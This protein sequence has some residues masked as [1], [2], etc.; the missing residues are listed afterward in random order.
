MAH[1]RVFSFLILVGLGMALTGSSGMSALAA[2]ATAER[3]VAVS[4]GSARGTLIEGRCPTFSWGEVE[5]A[6]AYELVVVRVS[7]DGEESQAV[8]RER[9]PGTVESWTPSLDRCLD[10]G[11]RYAW[12]VRAAGGK[13]A[14]E[15]S[16]P[17]LF[18]VAAG[19]SEAEFEAALATV[20]RYLA[21]RESATL[22]ATKS[23]ARAGDVG[24][25]EVLGPAAAGSPPAPQ[26]LAPAVVSLVTEGAIGVGTSA[27]Q[28]DLHVLGSPT[29]GSI[30]VTP[31]EPDGQEVSE[32]FL[33]E[34]HDGSWGMK[35]QYDGPTNN[36]RILGENGGVFGP[37]LTIN[38]D[39][40]A[41]IFG[42]TITGDGSGLTSLNPSNLSGPVPVAQGGT[43]AT[44]AAGALANL[45]AA[46]A[47]DLH[48]RYT[49]S[50]AVA[51]MGTWDDANPLHHAKYTDSEALA[52]IQATGFQGMWIG[53]C[54]NRLVSQPSGSSRSCD[55]RS[56]LTCTGGGNFCVVY[57]PDTT[58]CSCE[59]DSCP[60]GT[61]WWQS[62][63]WE[64]YGPTYEQT[65]ACIFD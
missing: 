13:E 41:A 25:G 22:E 61:T 28:A 54:K 34:D 59:L 17:S 1:K 33:S 24:A 4:P 65:Y 49:D 58:D 23:E 3:P 8:L 38:R 40:G 20:E 52:A 47:T 36:L 57:S 42:G 39:S 9:F 45:G 56:P 18:E 53:S 15:W 63:S 62:G 50:E 44:D 46:A 48:D 29:L 12:S 21:L 10:R 19:P 31:N 2:A 64:S 6:K 35:L 55:A 26:P 30:L 7:A 16:S 43:G 5:G 60:A 37:W 27:P 32:L 51:A 11:G 14:A